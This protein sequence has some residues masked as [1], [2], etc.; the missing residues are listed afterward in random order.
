MEAHLG[1]EKLSGFSSL[2]IGGTGELG[3]HDR[4]NFMDMFEKAISDFTKLNEHRTAAYYRRSMQAY[5]DF[6]NRRQNAWS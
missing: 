5:W 2:P 4:V 3:L 6:M 1:V